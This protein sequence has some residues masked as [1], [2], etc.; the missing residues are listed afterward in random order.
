MLPAPLPAGLGNHPPRTARSPGAGRA[1]ILLAAA[2]EALI[3]CI[4][5]IG[6][7]DGALAQGAN[8]SGHISKEERQA[9]SGSSSSSEQQ[10]AGAPLME[11]RGAR[12]RQQQLEQLRRA[13]G[14]LAALPW[15]PEALQLH[16]LDAL[17]PLLAEPQPLTTGLY[18]IAT[19]P[20]ILRARRLIAL[21][22]VSKSWQAHL[23]GHEALLRGLRLHRLLVSCRSVSHP[24]WP[25]ACDQLPR[26]AAGV[27]RPHRPGAA[28]CR[29]AA[30]ATTSRPPHLPRSTFPLS[31]TGSTSSWRRRRRPRTSACRPPSRC[32]SPAAPTCTQDPLWTQH[33]HRRR[34]PATRSRACQALR[35]VGDGGKPS[36]SRC[37]RG[38][39]AARA[40]AP[41][42][43]CPPRRAC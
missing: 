23:A 15:L 37:C 8:P 9:S 17:V 14:A 41:R 24:T 13:D 1:A 10:H 19:G 11:T 26:P 2:G 4:L 6:A 16:V 40:R 42:W 34:G 30:D 29:P 21:A 12:Q 25:M 32:P 36:S 38:T 43:A 31:T 39:R 5:S 35:R 7:R 33:S 22:L 3:A 20:G 18:P 28:R 27:T